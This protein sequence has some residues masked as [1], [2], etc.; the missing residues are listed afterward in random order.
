VA[1]VNS[2]ARSCQLMN[3]ISAIERY[4]AQTEC[5]ISAT[6][7]TADTSMIDLNIGFLVMSIW[8][9]LWWVYR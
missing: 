9:P 8:R 4:I 7:I 6:Y 2:L 5:D 3:W 1:G